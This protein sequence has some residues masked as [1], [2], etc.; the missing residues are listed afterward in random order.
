MC[1]H[2][3]VCVCVCVHVNDPPSVSP[4]SSTIFFACS[5]IVEQSTCMYVC[6][7]KQ[8]SMHINDMVTHTIVQ[9][10]HSHTRLSHTHDTHTHDTHTH[11][12]T[13][14]IDMFSSCSGSKH[15]QYTR[16]TANIQYNLP[17]EQMLVVVYGISVGQSSYLVF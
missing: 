6:S 3:C 5:I 4:L 9:T 12:H 16:P 13:H 7:H 1:A 2:V 10:R 14:P 15:A 17:S 11:V 8:Y